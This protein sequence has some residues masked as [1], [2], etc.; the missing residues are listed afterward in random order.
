[1]RQNP[2]RVYVAL[3]EKAYAVL[4]ESIPDLQ[5]DS[6]R[7]KKISNQNFIEV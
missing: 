7:F 4:S 6:K 1:M 3:S 2:K 5:I